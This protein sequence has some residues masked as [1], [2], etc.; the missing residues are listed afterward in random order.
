[1]SQA[2]RDS[3][4]AKDFSYWETQLNLLLLFSLSADVYTMPDWYS[5][6]SSDSCASDV[7]AP[8]WR[9]TLRVTMAEMLA[10]Y[11]DAAKQ[12]YQVRPWF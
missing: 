8:G 11:V 4:A 3:K 5:E 6:S 12:V 9:F 1:M 10:Q 7:K 2:L